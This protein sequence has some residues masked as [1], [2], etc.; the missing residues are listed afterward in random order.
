MGRLE[1]QAADSTE[2]IS[3]DVDCHA[4]RSS[5]RTERANGV[6]DAGVGVAMAEE[7][8]PCDANGDDQTREVRVSVPTRTYDSARQWAIPHTLR[9]LPAAARYTRAARPLVNGR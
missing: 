5:L 3:A 6:P 4:R 8:V 2:A 9:V 1:D 7:S